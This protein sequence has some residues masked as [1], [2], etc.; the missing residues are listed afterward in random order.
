M[1]LSSRRLL[2]HT[3]H[4]HISLLGLPGAS[5]AFAVPSP[6]PDQLRILLNRF[7]ATLGLLLCRAIS[8][9]C[10]FSPASYPIFTGIPSVR[11]L[12]M[13]QPFLSSDPLRFSPRFWLLKVAF[14]GGAQHP[15][16]T[17]RPHFATWHRHTPLPGQ[18]LLR[19]RRAGASFAALI[20]VAPTVQTQSA[21]QTLCRIHIN[22]CLIIPAHSSEISRFWCWDPNTHLWYPYI[23]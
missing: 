3:S 5:P 16:P 6:V 4:T 21:P 14:G 15:R 10:S 8:Q 2:R 23:Y 17:P 9:P 7:I 1:W 18:S 11:I 13:T 19:V 20:P 22:F 12:I